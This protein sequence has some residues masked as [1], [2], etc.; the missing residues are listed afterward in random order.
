MTVR[1]QPPSLVTPSA[2][3]REQPQPPK[4]SLVMQPP[5]AAVRDQPPSMTVRDQPPSLVTPSAAVPQEPAAKPD[6]ST[7]SSKGIQSHHILSCV[8][9]ATVGKVPFGLQ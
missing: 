8:I 4:S 7:Q 2:A 6:E 9:V 1:D 5:S 3:V